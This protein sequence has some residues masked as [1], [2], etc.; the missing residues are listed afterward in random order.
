MRD[1]N[2]NSDTLSIEQFPHET[3][4]IQI[5]YDSRGWAFRCYNAVGDKLAT[6]VPHNPET[7]HLTP[8]GRESLKT[9]DWDDHK[10]QSVSVELPTIN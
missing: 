9:D 7:S 1:I 4:Q 2:L 8:K 5:L 10:P 6:I 3:K